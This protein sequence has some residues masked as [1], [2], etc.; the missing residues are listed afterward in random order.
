MQKTVID[1]NQEPSFP[2]PTQNKTI[3]FE[4]PTEFVKL[5][6]KGKIYGPDSNLFQKEEFLETQQKLITYLGIMK[7]HKAWKRFL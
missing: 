4:I 2:Q 6:S 5:P 7:F 1:D 3:E